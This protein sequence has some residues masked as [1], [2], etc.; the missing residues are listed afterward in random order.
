ED[1]AI[2]RANGHDQVMPRQFNWISA[3]GLGFSITNSWVGYLSCF[4]QSLIYGGAQ[5]C[6]FSLVVAFA[7]QLIITTELGELGSA[8]PS[9]GGQYHFCYILSPDNTK[10]YSAYIVG[11]LSV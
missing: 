9:S 1:D 4:G 10:R 3:L 6:I 8:F 7:I 2:L 11:W 5:T